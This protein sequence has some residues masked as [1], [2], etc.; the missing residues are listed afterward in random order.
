VNIERRIY[1]KLSERYPVM[2]DLPPMVLLSINKSLRKLSVLN[3]MTMAEAF[4]K[5]W[6]CQPLAKKRAPRIAI[7]HDEGKIVKIYKDLVWEP[8]DP[9]QPGY[10][11]TWA[12]TG[13]ETPDLMRIW[14]GMNLSDELTQPGMANPVRYVN[15]N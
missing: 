13:N 1:E 8:I 5:A 10:A 6:T 14:G 12:F 7:C 2:G 3:D 15:C 9:V 4:R 11:T